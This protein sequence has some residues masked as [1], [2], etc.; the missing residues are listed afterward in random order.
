M[1]EIV[2]WRW[3][4]LAQVASVL[5]VTVFMLVLGRSTARRG[6][7]WLIA[8]WVCNAAAMLLTLVY[9][10][11][12]PSGSAQITVTAGY[13]FL[14]TLFVVLLGVGAMAFALPGRRLPP[15]A[16]LVG[17]SAALAIPAAM[18]AR[19]IDAVGLMQ[20]GV[21]GV[22]LCASAVL[23]ARSPGRGLGWLGV[24]FALRGILGLVEAAAYGSRLLHGD[25]GPTALV[26]I[27]LAGHSLF[28]TGAEW[29]IALG[30]VLAMAHLAQAE[31]RHANAE[32]EAAHRELQ[33]VADRD[34]L[35]G[36][37]NRRMLPA[38]LRQ[39]SGRDGWLLFL[40]LD[41]FKRI[42]DVEGHFVG[43]ACLRRFAQA[44]RDTFADDG[45]IL[46]FAGDE[47]VVVTGAQPEHMVR[48]SLAQLRETIGSPDGETPGIQ[49]SV[50]L[51]A[52]HANGD[53]QQSLRDADA[54]MY[55]DKAAARAG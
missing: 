39:V 42:N 32:L 22:V 14:K 55:R 18:F 47:F 54:A 11:A 5:M 2:L 12:Q 34:P 26:S 28:D 19:G 23:C 48:A 1:D 35:T 3:S 30:G 50:G 29:A 9:W 17:A 40:D 7:R 16:L 51:A 33:E 25:P 43:D 52:L 31:L 37:A 46:R 6:I 38:L 45:A 36:L 41:G 8:A 24:G 49:F 21:I 13:M 15:V 4:T 20:A 53:P 27:F 44:L 10:F